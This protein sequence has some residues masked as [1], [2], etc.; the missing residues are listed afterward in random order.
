MVSTIWPDISNMADISHRELAFR[1][2]SRVFP[3]LDTYKPL[4]NSLNLLH[5]NSQSAVNKIDFY[6]SLHNIKNYDVISLNE[7]WFN[8]KIPSN[9]VS[10]DGFTLYRND[11]TAPN[12]SG[13][14]AA[15]FVKSDI[16]HQHLVALSPKSA[17]SFNS[18]WVKMQIK[19]SKSLVVGSLYAPNSCDSEVISYLTTTLTDKVFDNCNIVLMGD[20]N[21]N[22]NAHSPIKHKLQ[23]LFDGM[24]MV[25]A[26]QGCTFVSPIKG[27]ESLLDL[28][29]ISKSLTRHSSTVLVSRTS[30]HYATSTSV[31]CN[32]TRKPRQI[33]QSRNFTK[34]L[35]TLEALPCDYNLIRNI[36]SESNQNQPS[37]QA[38]LLDDWI[39][40]TIETVAPIKN[41]RIR[42]DT[43]AWLNTELRHLI[44]LKNR[45]YRRV[46][47]LPFYSTQ[48][49]QY[50]KFR[51]YVHTQ[52][53][54]GK[55]R[56]YADKFSSNS[57][58]FYKEAN[59]LLG[60]SSTQRLGITALHYNDELVEKEADIANLLN[61]YFTSISS[62]API[63][64]S[65]QP[66]QDVSDI[67]F[68]F[69]N[70]TANDV[71]KALTSPNG[72]EWTLFLHLFTR[73]CPKQ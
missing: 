26:I 33:V 20:F 43:P 38:Q 73:L 29:F 65:D 68:T 57:S 28:T 62:P 54:T 58:T 30:D 24:N 40:K 59:R 67:N 48:W 71:S 17:A 37:V 45:Y 8:P 9:L 15:L 47:L 21:V 32:S 46:R 36:C 14:G 49:C 66:T 19:N 1:L 2:H 39:S 61:S 23:M 35:S 6:N 55:K 27:K 72:V 70:V 52:L 44:S 50:K 31:T 42:P 13:G 12:K 60:R 34:A 5:H 4:N 16:N 11:R 63:I 51:N 3:S 7:T 64:P 10:I 56:F 41:Y 69:S 25:Q 53:K 18:L 22:W